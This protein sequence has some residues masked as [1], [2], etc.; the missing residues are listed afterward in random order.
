MYRRFSI[1]KV[2]GCVLVEFDRREHPRTKSPADTSPGGRR[3]LRE[4]LDQRALIARVELRHQR[5]ANHTWVK[6]SD[7]QATRDEA[8][9]AETRH[10]LGRCVRVPCAVVATLGG[11]SVHTP[12]I[13]SSF[14][15]SGRVFGACITADGRLLIPLFAVWKTGL[16]ISFSIR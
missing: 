9:V 12:M 4:Q 8:C 13:C 3:P 14:C 10:L 6:S 2:T 15:S 16:P 1:L 11:L 7:R 5:L